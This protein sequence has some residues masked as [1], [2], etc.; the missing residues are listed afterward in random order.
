MRAHLV[1]YLPR[2]DRSVTRRLLLAAESGLPAGTQIDRLELSTDIPELF[3]PQRLWAYI[4]RQYLGNTQDAAQKAS[5]AKM[6]DL[7][8]RL[9]KA[10]ILILAA[11]MHNFSFPAIVKAWFDSVMLKGLTWDIDPAKGYVGRCQGRRA[12]VLSSAGGI[13]EGDWAP[14]DHFTPLAKVEF[15]FMGFDRT[16]VVFASGMG[17]RSDADK[18][19]EITRAEEQAKSFAAGKL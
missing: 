16:D 1:S 3:D 18:E 15:G 11:P 10:E 8:Q 19:T 6:E 7:T 13:Y 14:Y 9:L 4:N 2:G 17:T 12:I 5:M